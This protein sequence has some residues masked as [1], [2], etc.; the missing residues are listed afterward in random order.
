MISFPSKSIGSFF[1]NNESI[2][3]NGGSV[4]RFNFQSKE[5]GRGGERR[6][7]NYQ[8][9]RSEFFPP[10]EI[11]PIKILTCRH[12]VTLDQLCPK[13]DEKFV[14]QSG[15]RFTKERKVVLVVEP[16]TH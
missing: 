9:M 6:E 14:D 11:V 1:P 8:S 7:I 13:E 10:P 15:V 16:R 5:W 4:I 12:D 2:K 3:K